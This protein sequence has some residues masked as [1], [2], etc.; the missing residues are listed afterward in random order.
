MEKV[1]YTGRHVH[2]ST[3]PNQQGEGEGRGRRKINEQSERV[4]VL[5]IPSSA[6]IWWD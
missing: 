5:W 1:V 4:P 2:T 6:T 3:C